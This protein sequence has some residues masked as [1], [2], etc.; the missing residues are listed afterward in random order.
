E[1]SL[2]E[3]FRVPRTSPF[4]RNAFFEGYQRVFAPFYF[5]SF[6]LLAGIVMLYFGH[7]SLFKRGLIALSL[8]MGLQLG[9]LIVLQMNDKFGI[10]APVLALLILLA[11]L[12][13]VFYERQRARQCLVEH[14]KA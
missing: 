9:T 12:C 4:A 14:R 5:L 1:R 11:P 8:F 3:L 6:G 7:V 2:V 10:L 13:V